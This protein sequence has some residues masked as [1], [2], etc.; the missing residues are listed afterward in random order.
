MGLLPFWI[1]GLGL[2][3]FGV[4]LVAQHHA[5]Y[6]RSLR[7]PHTLED[8]LHHLR[9]RYLRRMQTSS[10]LIL[11][12]LLIVGMGYALEWQRP[13]LASIILIG[14]IILPLWMAMMAMGD[15]VSTQGYKA[16]M[17]RRLEGL[18]KKQQ[19]LEQAADELQRTSNNGHGKGHGNG[20]NGSHV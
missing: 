18:H 5:S 13:L 16:R 8:E 10:M 12:G 7:D 2:V 4:G 6:S 11:C 17:E 19:E 3:V 1:F 9:R 15:L 14:I 20:Q